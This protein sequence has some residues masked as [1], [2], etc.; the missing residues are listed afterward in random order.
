MEV[1]LKIKYKMPEH[2]F[3]FSCRK[4]HEPVALKICPDDGFEFFRHFICQVVRMLR[5]CMLEYAILKIKITITGGIA[6]VGKEAEVPRK[7][8]HK[9]KMKPAAVCALKVKYLKC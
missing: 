7:L 3:F 2:G 9:E 5:D 8:A 4:R 6:A 1:E